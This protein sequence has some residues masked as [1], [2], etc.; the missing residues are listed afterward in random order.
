MTPAEL[1]AVATD[2]ERE[3]GAIERG[4]WSRLPRPP[5]MPAA[6]FCA[7]LR[8]RAGLLLRV[9]AT[10]EAC[11]RG[12]GAVERAR[13]AAH[14]EGLREVARGRFRLAAYMQHE[15]AWRAEVAEAAAEHRAFEV[16]DPWLRA[17]TMASAPIDPTTRRP[18]DPAIEEAR[19]ALAWRRCEQEAPRMLREWLAGSRP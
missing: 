17:V 4:A 6:P 13:V 19:N 9:A 7:I 2:A 1:R 3:T 8:A 14:F 10:A 18:V 15:R 5:M 16:L 11:E 12:D